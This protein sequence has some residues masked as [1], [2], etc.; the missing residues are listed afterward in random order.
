MRYL[1]IFIFLILNVSSSYA[2]HNRS[3][4]ITYEQIGPVT[5][6]ATITTY[7][8][9]S[10][11]GVDR[12]SLTLDWGDDTSELVPRTNSPGV[13]IPGEDVKV[14]V[15]TAEH[16]YPGRATYTLSFMDPNRVNN[17]QNVNFPNSV[18]VPFYVQTTFTFVNPQFQGFNSSVI[19]L[20]P[21]IDFACVGQQFIHN[22]NAFDPDG[23][24][25]SYELIPP[26]QSMDME[27]PRY[28]F[29][30]E[31]LPGPNNV[32]SL[33]EITGDFVWTSPQSAGEY[34]IAIK[35]NEFRNGVLL[36][37]VVRDM[38]IFVDVC[39][40]T[41]PTIDVIDEICVIAGT[42]LEIPVTVDD[43]DEGQQVK[44]TATGGPFLER[45]SSAVITG[46]DMFDDVERTELFIWETQCEHI[47]DSYYQVV[48]RAEDNS[49]NES[50]GLSILKTLRIKVVGPPPE[51]VTADVVDNEAIRIEWEL[52]YD[53]ATTI[54]DYFIGFSVW[55]K[56]QSNPFE[57]DTCIGGLEGRGYEP[58]NFLTNENDG[59]RYFHIDDENLEKSNIYCY[60]VLANFALRTPSG[61]PFN[62][63]ESLPSAEICIQ[64]QQDIPL[65]TEVSVTETDVNNGSIDVSWIKPVVDDL[66]TIA[67]PGPYRYEVL[68]STDAVTFDMITSGQ[69]VTQN[70]ADDID[71]QFSDTGLNTNSN[72]YFYRIDF[73]SN[74]LFFGSSPEASSVFT[75]IVSSDQINIV[76]WDEETPWVNFNYRVL[77]QENVGGPFLEIASVSDNTYTDEDLEND[78]EYCY[79]I[80]SEGT[81]G[82]TTT[83]SPLFNLSQEICGTPL[84]TVGP[85]APIL[86][87]ESPCALINEGII[88]NEFINTLT[89]S[90]PDS[91][92]DNNEDIASYIIY[93]APNLLEPLTFLAEVDGDVTTFEDTPEIGI[94]GCYTVSAIDSL[95][96]EGPQSE[97]VCV[98]S[99]SVYELPNTFTPNQD[100]SNDNFLPRENL[101]VSEVDFKIYNRWGN[102]IFETTDPEINWDGTGLNG[103]DASEGT[104]Y[105]TCIVF[106]NNTELG[107]ITL[108]QLSGYIQLHR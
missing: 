61:N 51:D 28:R 13:I 54:N 70:F 25:L 18:D 78:I 60:R 39:N 20:Q 16:T 101:F 42:R 56:I 108:D 19:L 86:S 53:C 62:I 31:I 7:T 103:E 83:P 30:N 9:A 95:G 85:C 38:Q 8:K 29:P 63:V 48:F 37:S 44:L 12:D 71:L 72:Q 59:N 55:R 99:C 40:N 96:N 34:N 88:V 69:F 5:I 21:P 58:V 98:E 81:Y 67:N 106:Q 22:P 105:Y 97:I 91:D 32:I 3:G 57:I 6:R 92:C 15:Y 80:E 87:V 82:L 50:S 36:N 47:S 45:F 84:D 90:I 26:F 76:S 4:E 93:F 100:G 41:I 65:I 2:T 73:Y 104:Y 75:S 43:I 10:S 49:L 107:T 33:D 17:I 11:T 102:L 27:V 14:N 74:G 64:L 23:D 79:Q 89:Y 94:T 52:P 1:I 66:D 46:D 24:S 77:R 35:I 68:R